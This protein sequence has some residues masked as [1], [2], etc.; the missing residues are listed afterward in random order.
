MYAIYTIFLSFSTYP[1][2]RKK[3]FQSLIIV[4]SF[5]VSLG[6]IDKRIFYYVVINRYE[7]SV[8]EIFVIPNRVKSTENYRLFKCLFFKLAS[9]NYLNELNVVIDATRNCKNLIF[10]FEADILRYFMENVFRFLSVHSLCCNFHLVRQ[11]V[12]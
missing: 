5:K 8:Q 2:N 1:R 3:L 10:H 7:N 12:T 6:V 11:C 9:K 4:V